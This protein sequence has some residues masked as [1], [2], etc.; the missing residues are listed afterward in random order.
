M[1]MPQSNVHCPQMAESYVQVGGTLFADWA[2]L[3]LAAGY[4]TDTFILRPSARDGLPPAACA[5][6][7][8]LA[9]GGLKRLRRGGASVWVQLRAPGRW[10][11]QEVG[12]GLWGAPVAV[13]VTPPLHP[14]CL[15]DFSRPPPLH[16][17]PCPPPPRAAGPPH[18]LAP[19]I[20]GAGG[21]GGVSAAALA[22]AR[23]LARLGAGHTSEVA[24]LAGLSPPT[25]RRALVELEAVGCAV[26]E[27]PAPGGYSA[28]YPFWRLRRRGL[29]LALRSWGV[30][31]GRA[32]PQ[33]LESRRVSAGRGRRVARLW[34]GWVRRAWGEAEVWAGWSEVALPGVGATPD[35]L[36]WGA[37]LGE[38]VLF[39]LEVE[40]GHASGALIR[41][42]TVQRLGRALVYTRQVGVR[43]VFAV[44]GRR[45]AVGAA[46][47]G[48]MDIPAEAAVVAADWR[49]FGRLPRP[50][51]GRV[52]AG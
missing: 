41:A 6:L 13:A 9:L 4:Y 42:R 12:R 48:L 29:S 39:W 47:E 51:W 18:P 16:P 46:C 3:E 52:R 32:F 27:G 23:V 22:C 38:E 24:A 40:S 7:V 45:W 10:Y 37:L 5:A 2:S 17:A 14:L 11:L 19:R 50:Q 21:G 20:P 43:L 26:R 49:A 1:T 36:A 44:L 30:A 35:A 31:P 8:R 33:R 15:E 28:R 25:A 34:P